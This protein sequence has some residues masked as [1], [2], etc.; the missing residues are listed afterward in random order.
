MVCNDTIID[1]I[2]IVIND[3]NLVKILF[4]FKKY[5]DIIRD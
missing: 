3:T 4:S 1:K 2:I 5:E